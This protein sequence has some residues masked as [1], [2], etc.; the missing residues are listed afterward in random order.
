VTSFQVSAGQA[1]GVVSLLA[2]VPYLVAILRGQ[3]RPSIA[4]WWIWTAVGAALCASYFAAG[5]RASIWTPVSYVVGPFLIALLALRYGDR[6]FS[7]FDAFCLG[8]AAL[9]LILWWW[10]GIPSVA[11]ALN[12]A[13]DAVGALPTVRKSWSEPESEDRLAWGLFLLANSLNLLAVT[14]WTL[15]SG[16][17]PSYLFALSLM[18]NLLLWR[19]RES[20]LRA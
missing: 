20:H 10:T 13:V 7:R 5:A 4:S 14:P 2:F 8:I 3:T 9:S 6:H 12:M 15:A 11:L 1:A 16:V 17:Y 18:M 19:K